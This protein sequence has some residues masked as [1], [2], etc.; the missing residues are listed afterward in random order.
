MRARTSL[1]TAALMLL[2][3]FVT[4]C[5]TDSKP[6]ADSAPADPATEGS[7]AGEPDL[8]AFTRCMRAE[9]IADFPDPGPDGISLGDSGIDPDSA[10]FKTAEKACEHLVPQADATSGSPGKAANEDWEKIVPGGDCECADGSEFAF[11]QRPAKQT[12]VVLYL[13]G[14]GTCFDAT[15]CASANTGST[16]EPTGPDYDPTIEGEDPA[17]EGGMLD[18]TRSDNPFGDFS[19]VYVPLCTADA[20]LGDATH[21]YSRGLSVSHNGFV[22]GTAALDHLAEQYPNA[23]QVV[24][25]GHTA[26]SIAAPVY[27]GLVA[28]LLPD[29]QVTVFGSQSGA[30]LD[31]PDLNA[32]ILGNWGAHDTMPDWEVNEGLTPRDWAPTQFWIQAG[33]HDPDIVMAR[34]DYAYD[35]HA[36]ESVEYLTGQTAPDLLALIDANDAAIED[37]GVVQHSYTAPGNGHGILEY[38]M[39]YELEVNGVALADW[40]AALLAGQPLDDVHCTVCAKP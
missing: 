17:R 26:G 31:E 8:Q 3:A 16:D 40:V 29:A 23:A 11:W 7:H 32:K 35:S 38:P 28:D 19:F 25:V 39:F 4:G 22:N 27:A 1:A 2:A 13:D 9:G 34:F 21:E 18:L 33:R 37:A 12:K 14:G 15:T 36:A 5:G 24:V 30:A 6:Q 20:H 10:R